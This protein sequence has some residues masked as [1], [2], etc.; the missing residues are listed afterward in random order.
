MVCGTSNGP[1]HDIGNYLGHCSMKNNGLLGYIQGG[2]G[3]YFVDLIGGL[4]DS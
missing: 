3:H 1:R 4:G 2:L